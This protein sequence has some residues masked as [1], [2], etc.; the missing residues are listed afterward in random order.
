MEDLHCTY[1]LSVRDSVGNILQFYYGDDGLDPASIEGSDSPVEFSRNLKHSISIHLNDAKKD[2]LLPW[3]ILR[4]KDRQLKATRFKSCSEEFLKA[5]N[6]FI[7]NA[8]VSR[9]VSSRIAQGL[10]TGLDENEKWMPGRGE[11]FNFNE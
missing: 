1:D 2:Y 4:E 10:S 11:I 8:V 7:Q 5:L 3:Q 6:N 9:L